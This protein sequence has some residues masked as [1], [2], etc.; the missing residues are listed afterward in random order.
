MASEVGDVTTEAVV[1]TTSEGYST[2]TVSIP[3][4]LDS[5]VFINSSCKEGYVLDA[6]SNCVKEF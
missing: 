2:T 3:E 4:S 1:E 5:R 6:N